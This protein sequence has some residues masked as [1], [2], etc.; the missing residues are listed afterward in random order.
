MIEGYE[1]QN[2]EPSES[3][4]TER[5]QI[6]NDFIAFSSLLARNFNNPYFAQFANDLG[7]SRL[8]R[9]YRDRNEKPELMSFFIRVANSKD[10]KLRIIWTI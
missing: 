1:K 9:V 4:G 7:F 5:E 8:F 3:D 10:L 2:S 6:R